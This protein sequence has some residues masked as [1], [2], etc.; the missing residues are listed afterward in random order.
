MQSQLN[1]Y[2]SY[3]QL[4][5]LHIQ[6]TFSL[7]A[8]PLKLKL[9]GGKI[10]NEKESIRN[11]TML[12]GVHFINSRPSTSP[13]LSK[14]EDVEEPVVSCFSMFVQPD[15]C[16]ALV[17]S[18]SRCWKSW[19]GLPCP[20]PAARPPVDTP[21]S[22]SLSL[23]PPVDCGPR[24]D[25]CRAQHLLYCVTLLILLSPLSQIPV[26]QTERRTG[27]QHCSFPSATANPQ[28]FATIV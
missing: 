15:C 20:G 21:L 12:Q 7:Y 16:T 10:R 1:L 17:W 18:G 24:P 22:L 11:N 19:C 28:H 2:F 14:G 4:N 8:E 13:C 27:E 5:H 6:I 9:D 25:A 23:V 26:Q 3:F